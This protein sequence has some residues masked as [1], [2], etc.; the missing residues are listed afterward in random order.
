MNIGSFTCLTSTLS[1]NYIPKPIVWLLKEIGAKN[2][3]VLHIILYIFLSCINQILFYSFS[4][5][6]STV[7]WTQALPLSKQALYHLS[8]PFFCFS[9]FWDRLSLYVGLIWTEAIPLCGA[10]LD[11]SP[12]IC[13][14]LHSWVDRLAPLCPA[15][16]W[17]WSLL[18]FLL[19]WPRTMILLILT[20][21]VT[22]NQA[23]V[24]SS[25]YQSNSWTLY[26]MVRL[27]DKIYCHH[28]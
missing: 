11:C 4:F 15:I 9:Y 10:G 27:L 6:G 13:A 25:C 2:Y 3:I 12:P 24:T 1:L 23:W 17:N 20:S 18:I 26:I 8:T 14:S 16:S 21:W 22:K 7:S 5:F 19:G 28:I